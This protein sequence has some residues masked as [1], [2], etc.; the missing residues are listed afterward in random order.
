MRVFLQ[1]AFDL[2]ALKAQTV[3]KAFSD[4]IKVLSS[5]VMVQGRFAYVGYPKSR[6]PP[7]PVAVTP[8]L[9]RRDAR[10]EPGADAVRTDT[11]D[12]R[13][14][15]RPS[16]IDGNSVLGDSIGTATQVD[17]QK[18][19]DEACECFEAARNDDMFMILS[20]LF[21]E[22][23]EAKFHFYAGPFLEKHNSGALD[24]TRYWKMF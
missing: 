14:E 3:D 24:V 2:G 7:L 17:G 21:D 16:N 15:E 4:C 23:R 12:T 11:A 5:Y 19:V 6:L 13:E 1:K 10:S 9:A 8:S 22:E 20:L 18:H